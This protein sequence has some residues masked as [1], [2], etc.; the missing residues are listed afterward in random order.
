MEEIVNNAEVTEED[1]YV[2]DD[3]VREVSLRLLQENHE[4]YEVLSR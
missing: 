4:A 3:I 1:M 2:S